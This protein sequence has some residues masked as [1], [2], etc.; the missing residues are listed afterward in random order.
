M[1]YVL[2]V[3]EVLDEA[4]MDGLP[5]ISTFLGGSLFSQQCTAIF[6]LGLSFRNLQPLQSKPIIIQGLTKV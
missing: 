4:N 2:A 5:S 3:S 1:Q 6:T